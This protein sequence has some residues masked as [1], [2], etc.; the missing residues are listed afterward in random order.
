VGVKRRC[1]HCQG[2]ISGPRNGARKFCSDACKQAAYRVRKKS[3]NEASSVAS[4]RAEVARQRRHAQEARD[5]EH[6]QRLRCEAAERAAESIRSTGLEHARD[7]DWSKREVRRLKRQVAD[8]E[9]GEDRQELIRQREEF[10][11]RLTV[12]N[13]DFHLLQSKFDMLEAEN[14][15][16]QRANEAWR[17]KYVELRDKYTGLVEE[18]SRAAAAINVMSRDRDRLRP[19][20]KEWDILAGRLAAGARGH[21]NQ[22]SSVDREILRHW[23]TWKQGV[24]KRQ[25]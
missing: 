16:H 13:Q 19:V 23:S 4:L 12:K 25:P 22:L 15:K 3:R 5:R 18:H 21:T 7:L 8:L 10:R 9:M 14:K 17:D 1:D 2:E 20:I 6:E 11:N 24:L